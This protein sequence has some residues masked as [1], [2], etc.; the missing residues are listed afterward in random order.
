MLNIVRA[1]RGRPCWRIKTSSD[2]WCAICLEPVLVVEVDGEG[3]AVPLDRR[4][5]RRWPWLVWRCP[6]CG[7]LTHGDDLDGEAYPDLRLLS[8]ATHGDNS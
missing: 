2:D 8:S 4:H 1:F 3:A 6:A 7:G 5:S